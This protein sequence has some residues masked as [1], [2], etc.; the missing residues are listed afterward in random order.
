MRFDLAKC[1]A[2]KGH[3]AYDVLS[4]Y[5]AVINKYHKAPAYQRDAVMGLRRE[6]LAIYGS[7]TSSKAQK[8]CAYDGLLYLAFYK[9]VNQTSYITLMTMSLTH[10]KSN[11]ELYFHF[12]E[13]QQYYLEELATAVRAKGDYIKP[14][15]NTPFCS[16]DIKRFQAACE[17]NGISYCKER[18]CITPATITFTSQEVSDNPRLAGDP[19]VFKRAIANLMSSP[20]ELNRAEAIAQINGLNKNEVQLLA[21]LYEFDL[22]RA[23]LYG[24]G[25]SVRQLTLIH[26]IVIEDGYSIDDALD[27]A[28]RYIQEFPQYARGYVAESGGVQRPTAQQRL[29][30]VQPAP[31][32]REQQPTTSV[33]PAIATEVGFGHSICSFFT[34]QRAAVAA[35]GVVTLAVSYYGLS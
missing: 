18:I 8:V 10:K 5:I 25:F 31:E 17:A 33:E 27:T 15:D 7:A 13:G 26:M 19:L 14:H 2:L 6:L 34:P 9:P 3:S 11:R 28:D 21:S 29:P 12:P 20:N 1:R 22:R 16:E 32:P 35:A 30:E 23:D 24:R 4:E